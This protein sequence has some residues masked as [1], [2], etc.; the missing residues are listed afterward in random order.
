V[1]EDA[2]Q[3]GLFN[4]F[5]ASGTAAFDRPDKFFDVIMRRGADGSASPDCGATLPR[6]ACPCQ[7]ALAIVFLLR[8]QNDLALQQASNVIIDWS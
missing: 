7:G 1:I 6:K 3:P 4:Q 8:T 5:I 2:A